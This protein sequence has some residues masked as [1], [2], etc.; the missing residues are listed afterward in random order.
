MDLF[1]TLGLDISIEA[2]PQILIPMMAI[3]TCSGLMYYMEQKSWIKL[4][5]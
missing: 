4:H 2:W 1:L 5:I 3:I